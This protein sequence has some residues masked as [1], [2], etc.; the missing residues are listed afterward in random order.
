MNQLVFIII[1]VIL[2]IFNFGLII[3]IYYKLRN[4]QGPIGP[5]GLQG[6]IGP[7]KVI[8]SKVQDNQTTE[9][10]D[11]TSKNEDNTK[12]CVGIVK[13]GAFK[14]KSCDFAYNNI[15]DDQ[16]VT[17]ANTWC[18]GDWNTGCS[19][20]D[21]DKEL[22]S[23]AIFKNY[24]NFPNVLDFGSSPL[25]STMPGSDKNGC[26]NNLSLEDAENKCSG[27]VSCG[28]FYIYDDKS[29]SRVCFKGKIDT[30]EP[31][32]TSSAENSGFYLKKDDDNVPSSNVP[33]SNVPDQYKFL[34]NILDVGTSRIPTMPDSDKN[35]CINNLSLEEAENKCS[36]QASCGGFYIYNNKSPSRV[37]FKDIIKEVASSKVKKSP[38]K[39]SGFYIN[40]T[41]R[42]GV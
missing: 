10:D 23:S 24:K 25:L 19:L 37:C 15:I 17:K 5:R 4:K 41:H 14:N 30:T 34:K 6:P 28:G 38:A 8:S 2:S 39:N 16:G 1:S 3:F 12:K 31:K 21:A 32:K 20:I 40:M 33:S 7:T 13:A 22:P 27:Q 26:I 18:S 36:S 11:K 29:P 35:G 42:A 9:E